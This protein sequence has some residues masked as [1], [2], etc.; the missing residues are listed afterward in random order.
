MN[1][2]KMLYNAGHNG[3]LVPKNDK[4]ADLRAMAPVGGEMTHLPRSGTIVPGSD[5]AI[6]AFRARRGWAR[7][8]TGMIRLAGA[9]EAAKGWAGRA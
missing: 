4:T 5:H 2:I 1:V 7:P 8:R 3:I 6:T 9:G